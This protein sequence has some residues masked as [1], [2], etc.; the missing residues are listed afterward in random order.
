MQIIFI[1]LDD[2]V[3]T[4]QLCTGPTDIWAQFGLPPEPWTSG[5]LSGN[6]ALNFNGR[7]HDAA[8]A[9]V[10]DSCEIFV[11]GY[12]YWSTG[13]YGN[14]QYSRVFSVSTNG[15]GSYSTLDDIYPYIAGNKPGA[16]DPLLWASQINSMALASNGSTVYVLHNTA[17]GNAYSFTPGETPENY[18]ITSKTQNL[19][20]T[21][22]HNISTTN[23]IATTDAVYTQNG[24]FHVGGDTKT[25]IEN[26]ENYAN[27][28]ISR[29]TNEGVTWTMTQALNASV[30][31]SVSDQGFSRLATSVAN[32]NN[33]CG[34]L[35]NGYDAVTGNSV[36][37]YLNPTSNTTWDTKVLYDH[38]TSDYDYYYTNYDS[39]YFN[40]VKLLS[41]KQNPGTLLAFYGDYGSKI[42]RFISTDSGDNWSGPDQVYPIS[43]F[44]DITPE[45]TLTRMNWGP[46]VNAKS[47]DYPDT[48][49]S[50]LGTEWNA[51]GWTDLSDVTTRVYGTFNDITSVGTPSGIGNNI[52]NKDLVM[53][54]TSSNRYFKFKFTNWGN[55]STGAS[56]VYTRQEIDSSTGANI[57]GQITVTKPV[58]EEV[59]DLDRIGWGPNF[60]A[61]E[62]ADGNVV[63][64][65]CA[66]V[67]NENF[68]AVKYMISTDGGSNF[69]QHGWASNAT[70][71]GENLS[72]KFANNGYKALASGN[73]VLLIG[74]TVFGNQ[75]N[76]I[77]FTP[78]AG[79][80]PPQM[81]TVPVTAPLILENDPTWINTT[82]I[83]FTGST[84]VSIDWGDG[85]IQEIYKPAST[86]QTYYHDYVSNVS[87]KTISITGKTT[88]ISFPA[89]NKSGYT[90]VN[91]WGNLLNLN[92]IKFDECVNLARVPNTAPANVTNYSEM[93]KSCALFNDSNIS[94]W[95][96]STVTNMASMFYMASAFNQDI[97]S[98]NT[99][100]VTDMQYMLSYAPVFNQNIG[101]WN[102]SNVT[103]MHRM[104]DGAAAFNQNIGSWNT[105][106]VTDMSYMFQ[107]AN[108]F[109]QPIGSWNTSNVTTM[110][111][112]FCSAASFNQDISG[113]NTGNVT[114]MSYMFITA[115]AFN[116][117]LNGWNTSN[118][119]DMSN[120]FFGSPFNGNISAW[121]TSNVSDMSN[122]LR[123]TPFNQP[124]GS[125]NTSNV[126]N[127]TSLFFQAANFNR[128]ISNWNTSNVTNM[129]YTFLGATVFNQDIGSWNVS[130]VVSMD[131]MFSEAYAFNQDLSGWC[132]D[133]IP[134]QP[135]NFDW[136]I[137]TT[138]TLP[139]P[140]WG[141]CP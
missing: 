85:N 113:W 37:Y 23:Q 121:N 131:A 98:W 88:A 108:A 110:F 90:A 18:L 5:R 22:T 41:L 46:L 91:S 120:M 93:F 119:I 27:L 59:S 96:T 9:I 43:V 70:L 102:T 16:Y 132:V 140:V 76:A 13:V 7:N 116:Q 68:D 57:S 74:S 2:V 65:L 141:T 97:G 87:L 52:K 66:E 33:Y 129:N 126:T 50:P 139:K 112:M 134:T 28:Y 136:G 48:G 72:D 114:N 35:F 60:D 39:P 47:E 79:T 53:R 1:D 138:W 15:G 137:T 14:S 12:N 81:P 84:H 115:G 21:W 42:H 29:S 36:I 133:N 99:G 69:I 51:D 101:G 20:A 127:M 92:S 56:F 117:S 77:R 61:V 105:G 103:N 78:Q 31:Y 64:V 45:I 19:G 124:I 49:L 11:A 118:V 100:N 25:N 62:L 40:R 135:S 54:A 63:V 71:Y 24:L 80:S 44:D 107:I 83:T 10:L 17:N 130:N 82:G 122:M 123:G 75:N 106:K 67:P 3:E 8:D 95:N 26:N 55:A 6:P 58:F 111:N 109:N 73:D 38:S 128:D 32:V 34:V 86:T 125:W 89:F 30:A 104:F 4:I 94:T